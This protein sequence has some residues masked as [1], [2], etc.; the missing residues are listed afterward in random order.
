MDNL[1]LAMII[2][3]LK[4]RQTI[5]EMMEANDKVYFALIKSKQNM[6]YISH[7]IQKFKGE[8]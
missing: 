6:L 3:E 8:N 1:E 4:L 2:N 5:E 7:L